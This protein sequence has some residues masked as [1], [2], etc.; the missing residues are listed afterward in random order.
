[1]ILSLNKYLLHT[2]YKSDIGT[3]EYNTEQ[4]MKVLTHME[5]AL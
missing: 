1:M 3:G 2:Y 5:I 4:H